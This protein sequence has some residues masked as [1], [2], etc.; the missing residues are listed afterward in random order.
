MIWVFFIVV[1]LG[2]LAVF[3]A[4]V[5]GRMR[6]DPLS[7]AV[8][9]QHDPGLPEAPHARDVD[10]VRFDRALRGYRMDQVDEVLDALRDTMA[11]QEATI[12]ALRRGEEAPAPGGTDAEA[13]RTAEG[14]PGIGAAAAGDG[15]AHR[16]PEGRR[17]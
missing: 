14:E 2:L 16:G 5:T 4:L 12:A 10:G 17:A 11:H 3:A 1:A 15:P 9:S 13:A 8:T 7:E 6:Y